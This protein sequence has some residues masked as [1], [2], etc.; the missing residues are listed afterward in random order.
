MEEAWGRRET[1]AEDGRIGGSGQGCGGLCNFLNGD[2]AQTEVHVL[3]TD[4]YT[5]KF[6]L[7]RSN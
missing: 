3:S 2:V 1:A 4:K 5:Y 6:T 7:Y